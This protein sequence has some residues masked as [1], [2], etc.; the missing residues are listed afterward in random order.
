MGCGARTV[1][2]RHKTRGRAQVFFAV[3]AV[4]RCLGT[5][6]SLGCLVGVLYAL[7]WVTKVGISQRNWRQLICSR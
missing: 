4:A 7:Q 5:S 6:W 1:G 3:E 2:I